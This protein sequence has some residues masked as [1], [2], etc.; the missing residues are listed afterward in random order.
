MALRWDQGLPEDRPPAPTPDEAPE[1]CWLAVRL[2]C[3]P[4]PLTGEKDIPADPRVV[5]LLVASEPGRAIEVARARLRAAGIRLPIQAGVTDTAS[6]QRW[7]AA[8]AF[9]IHRGCALRA[10]A[11]LDPSMKGL[12]HA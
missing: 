6:A 11:I 7:A 5:R 2:T 1:E 10:A 9:P 3:L 12:I 4:W 8:L